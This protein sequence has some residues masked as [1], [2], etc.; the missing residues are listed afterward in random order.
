MGLRRGGNNEG[1][2]KRV[3]GRKLGLGLKTRGPKEEEE[4][5]NGGL[6]VLPMGK[7]DFQSSEYSIFP[8]GEEGS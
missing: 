4:R 5:S 1:E 2:E 6:Y 8:S 7:R 3:S